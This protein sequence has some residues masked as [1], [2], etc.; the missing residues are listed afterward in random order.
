MNTQKKTPFF[1]IAAALAFGLLVAACDGKKENSTASVET[2]AAAQDA[3]QSQSTA[4]SSMTP[5]LKKD[6]ADMYQK[7]A[8]CL[9]TDM[10]L[11]QCSADAMKDCPVMQKT[12]HCP[13]HEGMGA[14]M[15]NPM[16]HPMGGMGMDQMKDKRPTTGGE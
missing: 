15:G 7:M 3:V 16:K 6:M 2:Q 5:E 8:D 9:R 4:H 10:S 13:I 1:G 12:G 11:D 14:A